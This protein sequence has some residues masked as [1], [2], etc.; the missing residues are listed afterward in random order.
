[1]QYR[2]R[3][4]GD[5]KTFMSMEHACTQTMQT[6]VQ[7]CGLPN[8]SH[9]RGPMADYRVLAQTWAGVQVCHHCI[10]GAYDCGVTAGSKRSAD[11]RL[12][13]P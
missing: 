7:T 5:L 12:V 6:L 4:S 8:D 11:L 2:D 9:E 10:M 1:M 13:A 3:A